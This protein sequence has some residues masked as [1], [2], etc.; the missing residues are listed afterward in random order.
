MSRKSKADPWGPPSEIRF[1]LQEEHPHSVASFISLRVSLILVL[2]YD[3]QECYDPAATPSLVKY[4]L[5]ASYGDMR[6]IDE[7]E[8]TI[9]KHGAD[10]IGYARKHATKTVTNWVKWVRAQTARQT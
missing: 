8:F 6:C 10:L 2:G 1:E 9:R 7:G 4:K 3:H 5:N